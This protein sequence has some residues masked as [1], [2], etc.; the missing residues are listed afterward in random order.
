V[1]LAGST[2]RKHYGVA[3]WVHRNVASCLSSY[4]PLSNRIISATFTA[5]PRDVTVLQCYAGTADKPDEKIEQFY[6][7]M[8]QKHPN[9][10]YSLLQAT[11]M[12]ESEKAQKRVT[13]LGNTDM[14]R[15][16]TEAR[17]WWI[18]ALN[19]NCLSPI[20]SP[21]CRIGIGTLGRVQTGLLEHRLTTF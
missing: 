5:K 2:E 3:I 12:L 10:T 7:E 19:E 13:F 17:H 20:Q 9:R 16:T 1:L 11:L 15:G 21:V 6:R 14:V 8:D 18:S 4:N